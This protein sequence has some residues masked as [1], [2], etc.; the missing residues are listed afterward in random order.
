MKADI[1]TLVLIIRRTQ[2]TAILIELGNIRHTGDQ[3]RLIKHENRQA[4]A[5][6]IL[7]GLMDY[8][9][10]VNRYKGSVLK[11]HIHIGYEV[12]PVYSISTCAYTVTRI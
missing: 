4:L 6:W 10:G 1:H 5:E 8:A 2:P 3:H 12:S 9:L 11:S 7:V